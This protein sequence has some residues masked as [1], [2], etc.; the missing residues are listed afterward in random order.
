MP[1]LAE[2]IEAMEALTAPLRAPELW[3]QM[4]EQGVMFEW[5]AFVAASPLLRSLGRG[6]HHPVFVMPGFLGD[7]SSTLPLRFYIRSWG[8]W[9]HGMHGGQNPGPTPKLLARVEERLAKIHDRHGRKVTLVGWSAGGQYA[10]HLARRHPEMVR[11]VITLA[12]PLQIHPQDRSSM[13][14]I[15]DRLEHR[16]DPEFRRL[17]DHERGPL[18]VPST[19]IYSR[20]DGVVRWQACLDIGDERHENVEVHGSHSGMGFNPAALAV[21][22]DRL[23]QAEDDW[24]P[25]YAPSFMRAFYPRP[26]SW[27]PH[28]PKTRGR[29]A[30]LHAVPNA[31]VSRTQLE[32]A[33]DPIDRLL[34]VAAVERSKET[35]DVATTT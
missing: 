12:T 13:S 8:F 10:R 4:L 19:S 26:E 3:V 27:E 17:A 30:R 24:R 16:F 25:F 29:R 7:D 1:E 6:D 34:A 18:P 14:F 9:A 2:P 20:T 28:H 32:Q 11:Q 5:G 35:N 21:V 15:A 23:S 33:D 31:K 22:A